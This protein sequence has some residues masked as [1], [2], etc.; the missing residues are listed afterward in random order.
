MAH[1]QTDPALALEAANPSMRAAPLQKPTLRAYALVAGFLACFCVG[2]AGVTQ[3]GAG[4]LV[5]AD[6][7]IAPMGPLVGLTALVWLTMVVVRN[8]AVMSGRI[9]AQHFVHAAGVSHDERIERPARAFNNLFQV[10]MLFY[11]ACLLMLSRGPV[12]LAQLELGWMF[13]AMRVAHA[14]VYIGWNHLPSRFA[15][16]IAGCITLG[17]IWVRLIPW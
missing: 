4:A 12:D 5:P 15:T 3:S 10:P 8:A 11:V 9:S 2:L 13:V 7:L 16:W 14:A 1:L 6:A 17:V